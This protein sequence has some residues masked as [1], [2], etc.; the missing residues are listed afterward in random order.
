MYQ[1]IIAQ[2]RFKNFHFKKTLKVFLVLL[3]LNDLTVALFRSVL[4]RLRWF[5]SYVGDK[6]AMLNG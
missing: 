5:R 4:K 2:F 3:V 1:E 6:T